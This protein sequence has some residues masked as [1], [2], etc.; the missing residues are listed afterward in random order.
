MKKPLRRRLN[1]K[2]WIAWSLSVAM[3]LPFIGNIAVIIY[4]VTRRTWKFGIYL[5]LCLP[6]VLLLML[7]FRL[8]GIDLLAESIDPVLERTFMFIA[9]VGN[10]PIIRYCMHLVTKDGQRALKKDSEESKEESETC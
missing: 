4:M 5:S 2:G 10:I 7:F 9:G 8:I 6:W 3:V 1:D